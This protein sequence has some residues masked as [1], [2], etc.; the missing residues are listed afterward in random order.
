MN[1]V[2][3][4]FESKW[5]NLEVRVIKMPFNVSVHRSLFASKDKI[6][7]VRQKREKIGSRAI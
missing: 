7:L 3:A 1:R 2:V 4:F 5:I 6:E